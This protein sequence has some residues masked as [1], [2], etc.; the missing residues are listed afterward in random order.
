MPLIFKI[1]AVWGEWGER[2]I[3]FLNFEIIAVKLDTQYKEFFILLNH[4]KVKLLTRSVI[5]HDYFNIYFPQRLF[6][7]ITTTRLSKLFYWMFL[8]FNLSDISS[9]LESH[10]ASLAKISEKWCCDLIVA[11]QV[12]HSFNLSHCWEYSLWSWLMLYLL[13][14]STVKILFLVKLVHILWGGTL[15]LYMS[16]FWLKFYIFIYLFSYNMD[17]WI[18]ISFGA[19]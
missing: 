1:Y 7:N 11:Y 15:K 19:L 18:P 8:N 4:L 14:V 6:F 9:C 5:S 13:G 16:H 17:S 12:V 2:R 10:C 3:F